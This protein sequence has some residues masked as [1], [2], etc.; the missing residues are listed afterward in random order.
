MSREQVSKVLIVYLQ[1]WHFDAGFVRL[2]GMCWLELEDWIQSHS[3]YTTDF[4]SILSFR[5]ILAQ[6]CVGLSSASN[7]ISHASNI[8]S[9]KEMGQQRGKSV[10]KN[11]FIVLFFLEYPVI[12]ELL[13]LSSRILIW[14]NLVRETYC[15]CIYLN[16]SFPSNSFVTQFLCILRSD[17]NEDLEGSLVGATR[18]MLEIRVVV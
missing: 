11:L 3:S 13:V 12:R 6:H 15:I 18:G 2:C 5:L 7:T 8:E 1:V 4:R 16:C 9:F 14:K 10:L 17:S